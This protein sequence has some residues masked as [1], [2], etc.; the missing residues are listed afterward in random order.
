MLLATGHGLSDTA[1]WPIGYYLYLLVLERG[2]RGPSTVTLIALLYVAI[3]GGFVDTV[4]VNVKLFPVTRPNTQKENEIQFNKFMT[5]S[6]SNVFYTRMYPHS[7]PQNIGRLSH[8][9]NQSYL[10]TTAQ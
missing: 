3:C 1:H 7:R 9:K 6:S 4:M 8:R 5:G 2:S 10:F